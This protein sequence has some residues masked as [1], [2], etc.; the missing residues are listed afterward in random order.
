MQ[1]GTNIS[2]RTM[3]PALYNSAKHARNQCVHVID[4]R[5]QAATESDGSSFDPFIDRQPHTDRR[6][7]GLACIACSSISLACLDRDRSPSVSR[8]PQHRTFSRSDEHMK[9]HTVQDVCKRV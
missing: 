8:G 4:A 3:W 1:K 9:R 7:A 2:I 6:P 5:E